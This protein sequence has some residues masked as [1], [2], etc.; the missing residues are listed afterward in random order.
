[1]SNEI[2]PER[3][4]LTRVVLITVLLLSVFITAK[5]FIAVSNVEQWTEELRSW[6]MSD[7]A[8]PRDQRN[9]ISSYE[10]RLEE[11]QKQWTVM[12]YVS[13]AANVLCCYG[14]FLVSRCEKPS[15][16]KTP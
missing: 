11:I 2:I 5:S 4:N 16:N 13:L 12:R 15:A 10:S 6:L 7:M 1:M 14:I 3:V 9:P 8:R